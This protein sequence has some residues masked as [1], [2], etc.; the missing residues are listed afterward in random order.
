MTLSDAAEQGRNGSSLNL[1]DALGAGLFVGVSGTIFAALRDAR[2]DLSVTFGAVIGSMALVAL[3]AALTSL[4][5]GPVRNEFT[6]P[7]HAQLQQQ[8]GDEHRDREQRQR[9][10]ARAAGSTRT[11]AGAGPA[12]CL[13][14]ADRGSSAYGSGRP[15]G[16]PEP[17]GTRPAGSSAPVPDRAAASGWSRRHRGARLVVRRGR[18]RVGH[19]GRLGRRPGSAGVP[20]GRG[21]GRRS[22]CS[23][24]VSRPS[25]SSRAVGGRRFRS[26]GQTGHHHPVQDGGRTQPR[27]RSARRAGRRVAGQDVGDAP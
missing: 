17:A 7:L 22:I 3:L 21:P 9:G 14:R 6:G 12:G 26:A 27:P 10:D 23:A 18:R 8:D 15:C 4:R 1:S 5:I 24:I 25:A 19:D 2:A 16:R 20:A 13:G 11:P